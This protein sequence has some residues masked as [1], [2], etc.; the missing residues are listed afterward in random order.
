MYSHF[1]KEFLMVNGVNY[2]TLSYTCTK[3]SHK[4]NKIDIDMFC[5]AADSEEVLLNKNFLIV[6]IHVHT[7]NQ[8]LYKCKILLYKCLEVHETLVIANFSFRKPVLKCLWYY[9]LH[10]IKI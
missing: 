10:I 4:K 9:I 2:Q 6:P 8:L 3:N 1:F 5:K 7:T